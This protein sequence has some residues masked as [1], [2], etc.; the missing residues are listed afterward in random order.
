M[1]NSTAS[2]CS[3]GQPKDLFISVHAGISYYTGQGVGRDVDRD[4]EPGVLRP[5]KLRPG[6]QP[7]GVNSGPHH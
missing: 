7:A 2:C 6:L 5:G 1:T 4:I 3:F